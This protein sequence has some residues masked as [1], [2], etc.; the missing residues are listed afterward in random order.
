MIRPNS[1]TARLLFVVSFSALL[2]S[3]S[4]ALATA[5]APPLGSASG[6]AALA[7]TAIT[8]TNSQLAGNV[9]TWPGTAVTRTGCPVAGTIY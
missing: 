2:Y 8:C 3:N 5:F 4:P 9:G 6:F 1:P 7:G